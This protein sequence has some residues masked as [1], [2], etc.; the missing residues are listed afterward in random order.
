M[1]SMSFV[2]E[3]K[4]QSALAPN[5][6]RWGAH[7]TLGTGFG[8]QWRIWQAL[9]AMLLYAKEDTLSIA[10]LGFCARS[11]LGNRCSGRPAGG[12]VPLADWDQAAWSITRL[13]QAIVQIS[14]LV[15]SLRLGTLTTFKEEVED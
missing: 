15:F 14:N 10:I 13:S 8:G 7:R 5:S 6:P 2:P 4:H 9:P 11:G 3:R 1:A 12:R